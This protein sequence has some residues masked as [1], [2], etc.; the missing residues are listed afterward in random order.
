MKRPDRGTQWLI[1]ALLA[2]LLLLLVV[3]ALGTRRAFSPQRTAAAVR[4]E[5]SE[6]LDL[7]VSRL[8]ASP[9]PAATAAA[10]SP[11]APTPTAAARPALRTLAEGRGLAVGVAVAPGWLQDPEYAALLVREF[12]SVTPENALKWDTLHPERDRYDFSEGDAIVEFARRNNLKVHGHVLVWFN[13]LPEWVQE[14]DYTRD[15]WI[16]I[17]REHITTVV[18]HFRGANNEHTVVAWDVVNEAVSTNGELFDSFWLQKIGPEYIPLAFQFAHEADPEAKLFYNDNAGEGLNPKAQGIYNLVQGLVA[19]GVP[20]DGV[21]FQMHTALDGAPSTNELI[22]NM[23]RLADLGLEV[24]IT[25]MDVRTQYRGDPPADELAAQAAV[26]RQVLEACL[27]SPN[28]TGFFT[29]G[30]TDRFSWIPGYTGAPDFPLL[31]DEN[32]QPKPAYEA[33]IDLLL[34]R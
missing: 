26:Y 21:G 7:Q 17:L 34:D 29:W 13:Q 2:D 8:T 25:E 5:L 30:L 23:K 1:A 31:F 28:C 16:E 33:L 4:A 3:A 24:Q 20:I 14:G 27:L 6:R 32:Y 15:E 22:T 18:G 19:T 10:A 11:A 9:L 12:N